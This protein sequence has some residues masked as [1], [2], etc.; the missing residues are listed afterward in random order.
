MQAWIL[1]LISIERGP[2]CRVYHFRPWLA[3]MRQLEDG[4]LPLPGSPHLW[5]CDC[6]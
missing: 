6:R 2:P 1:F 5:T 4:S 3:E